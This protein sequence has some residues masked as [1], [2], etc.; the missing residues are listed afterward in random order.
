[1]TKRAARPKS[2]E[3][4][5]RS[6]KTLTSC[7]DPPNQLNVTAG[8]SVADG[9]GVLSIRSRRLSL[10]AQ[11]FQLGWDVVMSHLIMGF[12]WNSFSSVTP[13]ARF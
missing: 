8:G 1:M 10:Q 4:P 6:T 2:G 11:A 13:N 12:M 9:S 7:T 5:T 3:D